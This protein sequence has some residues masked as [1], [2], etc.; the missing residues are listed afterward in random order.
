MNQ[1]YLIAKTLFWFYKRYLYKN[2]SIMIAFIIMQM[3]IACNNM[4]NT[5]SPTISPSTNYLLS[6]EIIPSASSFISTRIINTYSPA[7]TQSLTITPSFSP[8]FTN[9]PLRIVESHIA[10]IFNFQATDNPKAFLDLDTFEVINN[11]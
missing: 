10:L 3:A 2:I 6:N 1:I 7:L 4:E 11:S 8:S 9:V 5:L